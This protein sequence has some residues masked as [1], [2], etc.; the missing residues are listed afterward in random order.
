MSQ[1]NCNVTSNDETSIECTLATPWV[2]GK[3]IPDVRL[4]E[5]CIPVDSSVEPYDVP[6]IVGGIS[7]EVIN[8]AGGETISFYGEHFPSNL[9]DFPHMKVEWADGTRCIPIESNSTELKC[10][11]LAFSNEVISQALAANDG[12]RQL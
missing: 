6:Y 10:R 2:S 1:T 11:N 12:R 4:I 9:A 8:A 7:P 3:W 5:G